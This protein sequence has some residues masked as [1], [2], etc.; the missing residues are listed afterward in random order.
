MELKNKTLNQFAAEL[1]R[2]Y[3]RWGSY[4]HFVKYPNNEYWGVIEPS[5]RD[6]DA[7]TRSNAR[8]IERELAA[9]AP[10][11]DGAGEFNQDM[12]PGQSWFKGSASHWAVGHVDQIHIRIFDRDG[13]ISP[14][15]KKIYELY[16]KMEV[17]HVLDEDDFSE[18]EER[19][20]I[21]SVKSA[22]HSIIRDD[23]PENWAYEVLGE[24]TQSGQCGN[25][26]VANS[27]WEEI[28]DKARELG[29]AESEE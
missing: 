23:A 20:A 25:Y 18:E 14:C 6:S 21:E 3:E 13:S 12:E 15:V 11:G 28:Q 8:V 7:L 5:H 2:N 17:Y 4:A 27:M 10:E 9:I 29:F 19:D 24:L 22:C 1:I 26:E 16:Q